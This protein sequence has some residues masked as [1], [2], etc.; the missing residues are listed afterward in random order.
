MFRAL[1]VMVGI[2]VTGFPAAI[3]VAGRAISTVPTMSHLLNWSL[4]AGVLLVHCLL[5][6]HHLSLLLHQEFSISRLTPNDL[7]IRT[8]H[9]QWQNQTSGHFT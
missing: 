6:L 3:T 1:V 2:F 5:M 4:L 8:S 9:K 7:T